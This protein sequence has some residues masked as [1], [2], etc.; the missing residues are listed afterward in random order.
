MS[1]LPLARV[2]PATWTCP[3]GAGSTGYINVTPG[4]GSTGYMDVAPAMDDDG[5][6]V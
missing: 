2:A 3:P 4:S 5:E 1:R 6:D